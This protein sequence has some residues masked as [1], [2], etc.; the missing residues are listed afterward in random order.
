MRW[1][2]RALLL[3][4]YLWA[5]ALFPAATI[6]AATSLQ[7]SPS[8]VDLHLST[9]VSGIQQVINVTNTSSYPQQIRVVSI[10]FGGLEAGGGLLLLGEGQLDQKYGLARWIS[11]QPSELVLE[12]G[13]S[14]TVNVS[15]KNSN[16]LSPGA[17]YGSIMFLKGESATTPVDKSVLRQAVT[18]LLFVTKD[19]EVQQGMEL[20]RFERSSRWW[21][22]HDLTLDFHNT[23]NSFIVPRGLA[24][25]LD[26]TGHEVFRTAINENSAKLLPGQTRQFIT[27]LQSTGAA[28]LPGVYRLVLHYRY[29]GRD[30]FMTREQTVWY[31][32]PLATVALIVTLF[33]ALGIG[34]TLWRL[35]P[36]L[37]GRLWRRPRSRRQ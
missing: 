15:I 14:K 37:V 4:T 9:T 2:S 1:G 21:E 29:D 11:V 24:Q 17:H 12:A 5:T 28:V 23:G 26:P 3:G 36:R 8:Q 30:D 34:W 10:D 16:E 33:I 20:T 22:D 6:L 7:I 25:V 35:Q 32:P 19:G 31:W 18:S 13:E 27:S